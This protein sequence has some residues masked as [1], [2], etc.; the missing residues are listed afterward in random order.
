MLNVSLAL[1]RS[2]NGLLLRT[3]RFIEAIIF[4]ARWNGRASLCVTARGG[5]LPKFNY[6]VQVVE[7]FVESTPDPLRNPVIFIE[8]HRMRRLHHRLRLIFGWQEALASY[9]ARPMPPFQNR[10][11]SA[12]NRRRKVRFRSSHLPDNRTGHYASLCDNAFAPR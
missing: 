11:G 3:C 2:H 8:R 10:K 5:G 7:A 6:R 1:P 12:H 4:S 9:F